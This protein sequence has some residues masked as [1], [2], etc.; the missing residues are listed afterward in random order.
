MVSLAH[1]VLHYPEGENG[2]LFTPSSSLLMFDQEVNRFAL[3]L[4][5]R[6]CHLVPQQSP[7]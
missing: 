6:C 5:P 2:T 4:I 7:K 1:W 3:P